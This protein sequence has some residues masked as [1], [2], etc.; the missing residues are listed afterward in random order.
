MA[1]K[2]LKENRNRSSQSDLIFESLRSLCLSRGAESR[3]QSNAGSLWTHPPPLQVWPAPGQPASINNPRYEPEQWM[4]L[5]MKHTGLLVDPFFSHRECWAPFWSHL[6]INSQYFSPVFILYLQKKL[7][8]EGVCVCVWGGCSGCF[9]RFIRQLEW[10]DKTNKVEL[11]WLVS[12]SV[13]TFCVHL[14]KQCCDYMK[15]S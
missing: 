11:I 2:N 14:E 1:K 8:G 3:H 6:R 15:L 7:E 10:E 13:S 4:Q 12:R 9:D 5:F